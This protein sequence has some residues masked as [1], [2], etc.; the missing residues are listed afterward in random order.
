MAKINAT[1]WLLVKADAKIPIAK[2]TD[3]KRIKPMYEVKVAPESMV[4]I[5]C[6]K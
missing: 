2:N 1:I 6:P 4:P 5:G 3:P